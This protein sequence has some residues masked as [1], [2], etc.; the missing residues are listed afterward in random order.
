MRVFV[1][2]RN[3][4]EQRSLEVS[5]RFLI[6]FFQWVSLQVKFSTD[7]WK[8]GLHFQSFLNSCEHSAL[9][10][11]KALI[12]KRWAYAAENFVLKLFQVK[13]VLPTYNYR[14][15]PHS[16]LYG[17]LLNNN[18]IVKPLKL[19]LNLLNF[20]VMWE[21]FLCKKMWWWCVSHIAVVP[22]H[23]IGLTGFSSISKCHWVFYGALK[24]IQL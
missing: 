8:F 4:R 24:Y 21:S 20:L 13:H 22:V 5:Q 10:L 3:L 23:G 11:L 17:F 19:L 16:K 1:W 6:F 9:Y 7:L 2:T 18:S 15:L 14:L 12:F